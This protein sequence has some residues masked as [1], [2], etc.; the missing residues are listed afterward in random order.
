MQIEWN[1]HIHIQ[2]PESQQIEIKF[3]Y[4]LRCLHGNHENITSFLELD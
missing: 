3:A 4:G 2:M 1:T